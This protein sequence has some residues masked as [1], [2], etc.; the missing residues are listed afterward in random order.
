MRRVEVRWKDSNALHGWQYGE[1]KAD[2]APCET[3]GY[4]TEETEDKLVL[5]QTISEYGAHMNILIIAKGCI[6]SIKELR[7][8]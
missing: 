2:L 6:E 1:Y 3:L 8:K 5:A 7:V 4:I